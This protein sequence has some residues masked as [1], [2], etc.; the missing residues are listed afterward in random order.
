MKKYLTLLL[1]LFLM[2]CVAVPVSR[3]FPKAPDMLQEP[4]PA[5]NTIPDGAQADQVIDTV[6]EN[7]GTYHKVANELRGWQQWYIEQ[8]KIF[9]A[10]N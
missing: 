5:L 3:N 7:Y 4:P 10:V 6:I 8:K 9:E 1:A 2:G